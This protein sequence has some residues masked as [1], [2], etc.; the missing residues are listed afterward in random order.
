MHWELFDFSGLK[1][2][3]RHAR[4]YGLQS[5]PYIL[6]VLQIITTEQ[7][8]TYNAYAAINV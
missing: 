3:F 4:D 6:K 7:Q 1:F 5:A 2:T 8:V